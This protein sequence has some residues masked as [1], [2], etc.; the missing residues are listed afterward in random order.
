MNA[1]DNWQPGPFPTLPEPTLTCS[2]KVCFSDGAPDDADGFDGGLNIDRSTGDLYEKQSGAWVLISSGGGGG[3]A[4]QVY[5]YT[6]T[7]PTTDGIVPT[8]QNIVNVAAKRD[9][10]GPI[11]VWN[12][13]AHVWA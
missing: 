1:T 9:G 11:F 7:D 6:T 2:G 5:E 13:V 10:T 12:K 3:G 8:N 4:T